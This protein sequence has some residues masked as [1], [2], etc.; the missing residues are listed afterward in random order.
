LSSFLG[1]DHIHSVKITDIQGNIISP[2]ENA[3]IIYNS[4]KIEFDVSSLPTGT[5]LLIL[6]GSGRNETYKP[7]LFLPKKF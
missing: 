6:E 2:L 3:Q 5:Y 7:N 4:E 1:A